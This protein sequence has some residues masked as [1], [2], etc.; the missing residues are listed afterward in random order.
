MC[1]RCECVSRAESRFW[2]SLETHPQ[3]LKGDEQSFIW[4][5]IYL[6]KISVTVST[7]LICL[8]FTLKIRACL[9][10]SI[11]FLTETQNNPHGIVNYE[12]IMGFCTAIGWVFV[13][14]NVC[15]EIPLVCFEINKYLQW[16]YFVKATYSS[17]DGMSTHLLLRN[18]RLIFRVVLLL[19]PFGYSLPYIIMKARRVNIKCCQ[20]Q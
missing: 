18:V 4:M 19:K 7:S 2:S 17:A 3:Y 10:K 16:F 12:R 20:C 15:F 6:Y 5:I 13:I 14:F 9:K 1:S 11:A 8:R